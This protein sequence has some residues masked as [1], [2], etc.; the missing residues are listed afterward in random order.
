MFVGFPRSGTTITTDILNFHPHIAIALEHDVLNHINQYEAQKDLFDDIISNVERKKGFHVEISKKS[1][2]EIHVIG[3]KKAGVSSMVFSRSS[4]NLS[5]LRT[6]IGD[7]IRLRVLLIVRNPFD[8]ITTILNKAIL[9]GKDH[10]TLDAA[11][12]KFQNFLVGVQSARQILDKEEILIVYSE[13][14]ILES[15]RTMRQIFEFLGVE[16]VEGYF[17]AIKKV[18]FSEPRQT[19]D[20]TQW[21]P[22]HVLRV[23]RMISES[24][25][26]KGYNFGNTSFPWD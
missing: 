17:D 16:A 22:S 14:L 1:F 25:F 7:D 3:D 11:I 2:S 6:L 24:D 15:E 13:L 4:L 26:L 18:L 5:T 21:L 9:K 19:R 12:D 10:N 23:D 20:S 8:N